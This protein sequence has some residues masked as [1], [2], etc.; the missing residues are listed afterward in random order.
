MSPGIALFP[1]RSTR[2]VFNPAR[3][4]TCAEVPVFNTRPFFTAR[5]SATVKASSAVMTLPL[6]RTRSASSCAWAAT[7]LITKAATKMICKAAPFTPIRVAIPIMTPFSST[8]IAKPQ[9][10]DGKGKDLGLQHFT[11]NK[12]R[13]LFHTSKETVKSIIGPMSF[14]R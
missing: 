11:R 6:K 2:I 7:G 1:L 8:T 10:L 9:P 3:E 12:F 4:R 13:G 14:D 5:P